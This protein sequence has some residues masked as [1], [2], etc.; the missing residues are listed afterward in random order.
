MQ[1]LIPPIA[2]RSRSRAAIV[3]LTICNAASAHILGSSVITTSSAKGFRRFATENRNS[4]LVIRARSEREEHY[5]GC[6]DIMI[7]RSSSAYAEKILTV[8]RDR[9]AR[10]S[11]QWFPAPVISRE[12][13]LVASFR[14]LNS[15]AACDFPD[16][17]ALRHLICICPRSGSVSPQR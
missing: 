12:C 16:C 1:M 15:Q 8:L 6:A 2:R 17:R 3:R 13:R 4:A 5:R 7:L 14:P 9:R 10:C 11:A